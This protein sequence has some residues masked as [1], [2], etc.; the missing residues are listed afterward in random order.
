MPTDEARHPACMPERVP[1]E[2]TPVDDCRIV[3]RHDCVGDVP[4]LPAGLH[5]PIAEVDVLAIVAVAA[6]PASDCVQQLPPHEQKRSEH[7]VGGRR[8]GGLVVE[9]VVLALRLVR[10]AEPSREYDA[11]RFHSPSETAAERLPAPVGQR[12]AARQYRMENVVGEGDEGATA[13]ARRSRRGLHSA[14]T[15]PRWLRASVDM[16]ASDSGGSSRQRG[17]RRT[18]LTEPAMLAIT[19]VSSTCGRAREAARELVRM[20]VRNDN[21]GDLHGRVPRGKRRAFAPPP[22]PAERA[23]ARYR[24]WRCSR[25]R[26]A[27]RIPSARH[28][29]PR[30]R[31]HR[32]P[33]PGAQGRVQLRLVSRTPSPRAPAGRTL[34]ISMTAR[35]RRRLGRA[36]QVDPSRRSPR[37]ARHLVGARQR[38]QRLSPALRRRAVSQQRASRRAPRAGS[39]AAGSPQP[40][41]RT[42]LLAT[43]YLISFRPPR[44]V[45]R[46]GRRR[47]V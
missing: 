6:I 10:R 32:R 16:A 37:H 42:S 21:R 40:Q 29:R 47:S 4:P 25:S 24:P 5:C 11:S 39:F 45:G 20:P 14:R 17:L 30:T 38:A 26:I 27:S 41:G 43:R 36:A 9:R 19:T 3:V 35:G 2:E 7:P 33:P 34:R 28:P 22:P 31:P 46:A 23:R 44:T 1:R 18:E 12:T 13:P 8:L 15:L